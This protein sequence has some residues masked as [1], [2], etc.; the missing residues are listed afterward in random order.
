MLVCV[1]VHCRAQSRGRVRA[2]SCVCSHAWAS[3]H[4]RV[5][6]GVRPGVCV[7]A[8]MRLGVHAYRRVCVY[9]TVNG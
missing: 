4:V 8:G 9:A 5:G 6:D 2:R 3:V 1:R 7:G